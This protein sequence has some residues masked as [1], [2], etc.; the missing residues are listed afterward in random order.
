MEDSKRIEAAE[1]YY[2]KSDCD[3][4]FR[5]MAKARPPSGTVIGN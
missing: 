5:L 3:R 4:L 1:L 2:F